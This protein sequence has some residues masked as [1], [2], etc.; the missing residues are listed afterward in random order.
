MRT[1]ICLSA[2]FCFLSS[3]LVF[4]QG[5]LE[6]AAPP[7]PTMK[8][9]DQVEPRSPVSESGTIDASGSYYLTNNIIDAIVIDADN[10][11]LDLNGFTISGFTGFGVAVGARTNVRVFNGTILGGTSGVAGPSAA[12][13]HVHNLRIGNGGTCTNFVD[14]LGL[15]KVSQVSCKSTAQA[16]I[17]VIGTT[18][19][20]IIAV[21]HDSIVSFTGTAET[22]RAAI[23]IVHIGTGATYV[24]IRN[25][26]V[27]GND[28]NGIGIVGG[29]GGSAGTIVGNTT[30]FSALTGLIVRGDFIVTKN[31]SQGN[32]TAN[33]ELESAPN[34]APVTGI[35]DSPGP[36]HNIADTTP[37]PP[38]I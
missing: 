1:I 8:T 26:R 20:P 5:S 27:Y 9:L 18:D 6:P 4:A 28:D 15:I 30:N 34:A 22:T 3:S 29:E 2:I 24:D 16:G 12:N 37:A 21:V 38:P 13:I 32:E 36:W 7:G 17:Q 35:N 33:F 19:E 23:R 11:D 10:V 25:N 31:I 14:P